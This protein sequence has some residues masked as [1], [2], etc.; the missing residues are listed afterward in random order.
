MNYK[1]LKSKIQGKKNQLILLPIEIIKGTIENDEVLFSLLDDIETNKKISKEEEQQVGLD[2]ILKFEMSKKIFWKTDS[3]ENEVDFFVTFSNNKKYKIYLTYENI[4]KI[5]EIES[6]WVND[7][8]PNTKSGDLLVCVSPSVYLVKD[9]KQVF[10]NGIIDFPWDE[11]LE[12][13]KL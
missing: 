2:K 12:G 11:I 5:K 13:S 4:F 9:F 1:T 7:V 6:L 3:F 8:F 10:I